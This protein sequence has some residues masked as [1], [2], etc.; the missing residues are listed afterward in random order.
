MAGK[1]A[2]IEKEYRYRV[3]S[4]GVR[5]RYPGAQW[6]CPECGFWNKAKYCVCEGPNGCKH[7]ISRAEDYHDTPREKTPGEDESLIEEKN[8]SSP[9]HLAMAARYQP[10][11]MGHESKIE[12]KFADKYGM[13]LPHWVI[14]NRV[15][16]RT[17]KV[18]NAHDLTKIAEVYEVAGEKLSRAEVMGKIVEGIASGVPLVSLLK[19]DPGWPDPLDVRVWRRRYPKFDED[20]KEAEKVFGD[21]LYEQGLH[22]AMN[23]R[24]TEPVFNKEGDI[25]GERTNAQILKLQVETLQNA[26]AKFNEKYLDKQIQQVE[27]ITDRMSREQ[28]L[29]RLKQLIN[30]NPE[31]KEVMP[32]IVEGEV[33]KDEA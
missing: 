33:V 32:D 8:E 10:G 18:R 6:E 15:R 26:A 29:E 30:E 7:E 17:L 16:D 23:S 5:R 24:P 14:T 3:D 20:L 9:M 2:K 4:A 27:D 25:V 11:K 1:K 21:I 19:S 13:N 12:A 31:L 22:V 28:M